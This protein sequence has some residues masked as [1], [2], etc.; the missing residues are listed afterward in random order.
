VK[1][2]KKWEKCLNVIARGIQFLHNL[3]KNLIHD[4]IDVKTLQD[5]NCK[6]HDDKRNNQHNRNHDNSSNDTSNSTG[7]IQTKR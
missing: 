1:E 2:I 6:N 5:P 3:I 4:F 7:G